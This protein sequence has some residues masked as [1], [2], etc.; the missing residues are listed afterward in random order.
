MR[1]LLGGLL[2]PLFTPVAIIIIAIGEMVTGE[3]NEADL[4]FWKGLKMFEHLGE[5]GPQLI[6]MSFYIYNNGG[7]HEHPLSVTSAVFSAGSLLI[8]LV[9]GFE[10][11]IDRVI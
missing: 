1:V 4:T 8:G 2:Y 3:N 11:F 10:P 5:A 7:H 6:L 9:T